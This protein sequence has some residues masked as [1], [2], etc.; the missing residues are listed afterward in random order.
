MQVLQ[1]RQGNVSPGYDPSGP[2]ANN[3]GSPPRAQSSHSLSHGNADCSLE[4]RC[5]PSCSADRV[6]SQVDRSGQDTASLCSR[7]AVL[8]AE[9]A[10]QRP[11]AE[12][13]SRSNSNLAGRLSDL[14]GSVTGAHTGGLSSELPSPPRRTSLLSNDSHSRAQGSV[15][16]VDP[17][18][19]LHGD[20]SRANF[21]LAPALSP[22]TACD[23]SWN[24]GSPGQKQIRSTLPHTRAGQVQAL[25]SLIRDHRGRCTGPGQHCTGV[26]TPPLQY[27]AA[28]LR[29]DAGGSD[30]ARVVGQEMMPSN[31]RRVVTA[32]PARL[33][34]WRSPSFRHG[35][36]LPPALEGLP[37]HMHRYAPPSILAEL[38]P[39]AS[40]LSEAA[41][42]QHTCQ[43]TG[44]HLVQ[45]LDAPER[46]VR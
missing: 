32:P 19:R 17:D 10:A 15:G 14:L 30:S 13:A 18:H 46:V 35:S 3:Q 26:V 39:V 23:S 21:N 33:G 37:L 34:G 7:I 43:G 41:H 27:A 45:R 4:P 42:A 24:T 28:R 40:P 16:A 11:T 38:A 22:A 9:L 2:D 29:D 8:E 36:K 31:P 12:T 6:P 44:S 5:S 20:T 25:Q 1:A